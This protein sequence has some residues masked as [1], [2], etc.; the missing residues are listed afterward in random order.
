MLH[1][2][3]STHINRFWQFLAVML[4]SYYAMER[5]F[6]TSPLLTNV[7]AIP[8]ETWTPEIVFSVMLG[9]CQDHPRRR[10]EMEFCVVADLQEVVLRFEFHQNWL[11]GFGAV[12]R[13]PSLT[14]PIDLGVSHWFWQIRPKWQRENF[15]SP[16]ITFIRLTLINSIAKLW[17]L[18][19]ACDL[20][21]WC[22]HVSSFLTAN[23]VRF[24]L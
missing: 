20:I 2:I 12:G 17:Q 16:Q 18:I 10:I 11:S 9:I 19:F 24:E 23:F 13:G 3:T 6:V 14:F 22:K 21:T 4:L 15:E 1:T 7:S 5:A 8:G